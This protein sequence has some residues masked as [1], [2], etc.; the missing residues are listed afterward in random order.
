MTPADVLRQGAPAY[1]LVHTHPDGGPPSAADLAVTRR[2]VA[3]SL[4]CEVRRQASLVLTRTTTFDCMAEAVG[5][6]G[7]LPAGDARQGDVEGPCG[8][9]QAD[10]AG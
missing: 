3:A 6:A 2:L 9:V 8:G 7:A 5:W 10:A 1:A 4:V